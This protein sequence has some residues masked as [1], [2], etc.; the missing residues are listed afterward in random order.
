[1]K[2]FFLHGAA[3]FPARAGVEME[4]FIGE[5]LEDGRIR[6]GLHREPDR[7]PEG[8]RERQH[9]VGLSLEGGLVVHIAR[10]AMGRRDLAG[11]VR[12]KEAVIFHGSVSGGLWQARPSLPAFLR[13]YDTACLPSPRP[14]G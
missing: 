6:A 2:A 14:L 4:T 9:G 13:T 8:V 7:Q 10:G 1:M 3:D 12:K 5:D 11:R